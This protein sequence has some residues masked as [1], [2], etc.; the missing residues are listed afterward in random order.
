MAKP[1]ILAVD[2][3]P[4]VLA[5]V[6]RD[7]R[8]RY[9][10]SYQIVAA[11]SGQDALDAV[12]EIDDGGRTIAAF[13]V[14]QRMPNMTGTEFLVEALKT[15]PNAKRLLLTAYADT[16]AAIQAIN[17]VGLDHYLLKPWAPPEDRLYPVLDDVLDDWQAS[18]ERPFE[19]VRVFGTTW[20]PTTFEVKAFLARNEVAYQ[21]LDIDRDAAA[22]EL[23]AKLAEGRAELPIVVTEDDTVFVNPDKAVLAAAVGIHATPGS[24]FYDLVIV[25]GGP[26]GLAAAVYGASEGLTT[27]LIEREAAGGQAGTSSRIENYLGFPRGV[28][29]ADLARRAI[30]QAIR[31]GAE[32]VTAVEVTGVGVEGPVKHVRLSDGSELTCRA[33][34]VASGMTVKRLGVPGY[35][36]FEGAGVYYGAAATEAATYRDRDVY[37]IGGANSAGQAAVM[38]SKTSSRVTM[39][40]RAASLGERMSQYLVDQIAGVPNIE[41]LTSTEVVEVTGSDRVESITLR[42]TETLVT[43]RREASAL[44]IFVGA[45]PHSS[46]LEGVIAMNPKGFIYTGRDVQSFSE[47]WKLK[48]DPF[49]LETSVPGVFAAGDVREGAVR[50]VASA[51]GEGSVAVTFVHRYLDTV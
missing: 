19:G 21:F 6:R 28:S 1:V 45:V 33:L 37:V 10:E 9:A 51:V 20:S 25:G 15:F 5:A 27:A 17:D 12:R 40:V 48:R 42:N 47:D 38:F 3:D 11:P 16:E 8:T 18:A 22:A 4:Q 46:F 14:D 39:V 24:P 23:A 2:D 29:G 31:L 13:V 34:V 43:E 30:A 26:A 36:R 44:F 32:L 35:E 41:V 50:R 7:L 49:A